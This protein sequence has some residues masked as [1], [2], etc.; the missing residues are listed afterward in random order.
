MWPPCISIWMNPATFILNQPEQS[1]IVFAA[2][3]TYNSAPLANDLTSLRFSLLK[4]GHNIEAFHTVEDK[5]DHKSAVIEILL[6]HE[7]WNFVA[8]VVEKAKLLP[9]LREPHR[10]YPRFASHV[11]R[12]ILRRIQPSTSRI[13][14]FTDSLPMKTPRVSVE[15]AIKRACRAELPR[16]M[17]FESFHHHRTSNAWIQVADYCSWSVFRKWEHNDPRA[18]EKL[19][20]R[21]FKAERN[22]LARATNIIRWGVRMVPLSPSISTVQITKLKICSSLP[23]IT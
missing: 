11:I 4:K 6:R 17:P 8:I 21:L 18:H 2:A 23:S 16:K 20:P 5:L 15:K 12:F 14:V 1:T 9:M 19:Q 10:F 7:S 22:I 3:W 13:L